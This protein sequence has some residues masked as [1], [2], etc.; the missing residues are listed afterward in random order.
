MP[1]E[2]CDVAWDVICHDL[3]DLLSEFFLK[4]E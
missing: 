2:F 4:I 3:I 1:M